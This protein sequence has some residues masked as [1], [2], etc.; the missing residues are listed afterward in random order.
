MNKVDK[1]NI[2]NMNPKAPKLKALPKIHK[3][4]IPIRPIVNYRSA[5]AYMLSKCLHNL[6]K[7]NIKLKDN[8]SL[9]NSWQLV[10]IINNYNLGKDSSMLSLDIVN[11][12][13]NMPLDETIEIV[14]ENL[15]Q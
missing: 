10:D 11:M 6:L 12:Y 3:D 5:P 7:N 9:E 1:C 15:L 13:T 14:K 8:R 4:A 2:I